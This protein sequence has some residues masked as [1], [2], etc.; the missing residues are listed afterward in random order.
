M[1]WKDQ[2]RQAFPKEVDYAHFMGQFSQNTGIATIF[3]IMFTKGV[4]RKF[5]WFVGAIVT[6]MVA[7][8]T[9]ALFYALVLFDNIMDPMTTAIGISATLLAAWIGSFQNFLAKGTKYSQFDPTKEMAYIPLDSESRT[10]GKA[11]VDVIGGRL[12][13]ALGGYTQNAIF[14]ITGTK[15]VISVAPYFA[16]VVGVIVGIWMYAVGALNKRYHT[17][18]DTQQKN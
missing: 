1:V 13:K 3:L 18:L 9:G 16:G 8:I 6:P 12:G 14:I 11:A 5:G 10:K 7:V 2:I 15:D 4:V 17:L